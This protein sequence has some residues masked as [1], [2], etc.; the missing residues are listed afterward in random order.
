MIPPLLALSLWPLVAIFFFK[1]Y[2]P[3]VAVSL[4]LVGGYL[5]LPVQGGL[6][7]PVLPSLTKVTIPSLT[8][9]ILG[10]WILKSRAKEFAPGS[11]QPGWLP[12]NK[13]ILTLFVVTLVASFLTVMA[14]GDRLV[15]GFTTIQGLRPYDAFSLSMRTFMVLL[16]LLLARKYLARPED[17]RTLLI[18]F[19]VAG[20]A[21][22][23]PA[24]VEVRMSPQISRWTYGFFP[25]DWRQHVRGGHFRPV[26]FLEHGLHL[27]IFFAG[28][29]LATA[30]LLRMEQGKRGKYL[31][32][33]CWLMAVLFLSRTLGAFL[34]TLLLLPVA[35][36]FKAR[37]QMICMGVLASIVLLY[38]MVRGADLV[39]TDRAVELAERIDPA[40]AQSLWFRFKNEDILLEKANERPLLGWGSWGR[41]RV[42]DEVGRDISVTDGTWVI[43][44]GSDGWVG[45]IGKFGL[46]TVPIILLAFSRRRYT[47][48]LATSGLCIVII[49]N[50]ADMIPNSSLTA[51]TWLMAG[52]LIGRL[53][54]ER[55]G[56]EQDGEAQAVAPAL[57]GGRPGYSRRP[58]RP[59][60]QRS[61]A[62]S[63]HTP[64]HA[65]PKHAKLGYTRPRPAHG[66][67]RQTGAG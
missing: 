37:L 20:L 16:P 39:P 52:A 28:A 19:C 29:V 42:Y 14:N 51:V 34:I 2:S 62:A 45:Y 61:G 26:I 7:L 48:T 6:N 17:H 15:Y 67:A 50:L 8:V 63:A 1:R 3:A 44:I 32:A 66:K 49:A 23:L 5:L 11:I 36:A 9:V 33:I 38:P 27:G 10:A 41:N 55:S 25:H 57:P 35:L 58:P 12:K 60:P 24:L 30:A 31:L 54:L 59:I 13:I 47:V 40:R 43:F 18:V 56:Q 53:E 65:G 46:L 64:K 4:T 21:Y 22:S